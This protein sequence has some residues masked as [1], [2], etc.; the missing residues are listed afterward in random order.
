MPGHISLS[1]GLQ[2]LRSLLRLSLFFFNPLFI[3]LHLAYSFSPSLRLSVVLALI[4]TLSQSGT[5]VL[6]QPI[7]RDRRGITAFYCELGR[8]TAVLWQIIRLLTAPVGWH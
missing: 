5:L 3:S 7:M 4:Q 6:I 2:G 1:L 8:L